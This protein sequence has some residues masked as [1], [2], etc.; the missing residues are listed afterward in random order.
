MDIAP[1]V[2]FTYDRLDTLKRT[3][4]SLETNELASETDCF[5]FSDAFDEKKNNYDSICS[6]RSFLDSYKDNS[7]FANAFVEYAAE[8]K[9]LAKSVISGVT[10][11]IGKYGKAI[12]VEDDL[13]VSNSFLRYM[14]EAL[15]HFQDNPSIWSISGF[16]IG[17]INAQNINSDVYL[18]RRGSSWGWATW[19]DRWCTV[20]WD[21]KDYE[22]FVENENKK[23]SFNKCGED[24]TN[25]LV[26]W[27]E[28][29]TDSWAIRFDYAQFRQ[30]RY[31]VFPRKSQ[32][33]NIGLN[34]FG[35]NCGKSL[36]NIY[37]T[38]LYNLDGYINFDLIDD[39]SK[40]EKEKARAFSSSILSRIMIVLARWYT[41]L[42]NG[43]N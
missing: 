28:K 30:G 34:G 13:I 16:S 7:V 14:N 41:R 15:R 32:V 43:R 8:H 42:L 12:I 20:D 21:V 17:L 24:L 35:T 38:Y 9:G 5:I 1:V 11:V 25:L 19:Y 23:N 27:K 31:T 40:I 36:L 29:K 37:K 3:I 4:E 26:M 22:S 18:S 10:K 39:Y 2:I 6:V 33:Q